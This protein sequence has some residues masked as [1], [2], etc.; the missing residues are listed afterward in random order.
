MPRKKKELVKRVIKVDPVYNSE[1]IQRF[2]NIVMWRGKK[3]VA[4][5]IV[6]EA[7]EMLEKKYGTK[8]KALSV[9][10]KGYNNIMP[11]IEVRSRRVG[12]SVYQI[13]REVGEGRGRSLALRWLIEV[14]LVV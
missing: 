8:E 7:L 4:R 13:P 10:Y 5:K 6:Y 3:T 11:I 1:L 2:I 9:F 14:A 12:G